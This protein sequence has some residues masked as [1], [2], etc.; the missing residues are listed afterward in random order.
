[1]TTYENNDILA[2]MKTIIL[3]SILGFFNFALYASDRGE[4][5]QTSSAST[6][7]EALAKAIAAVPYGAVIKKVNFNGYS[8]CGYVQDLGV[9]QTS[10]SY[11]C[12]VIYEIR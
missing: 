2:I 11:K 4:Y 12:K 3:F 1:L 6:K 7:A 8:Q 10:G 9:V 5:S